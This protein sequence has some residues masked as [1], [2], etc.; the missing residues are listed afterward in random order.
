MERSVDVLPVLPI[1]VTASSEKSDPEENLLCDSSRRDRS[2]ASIACASN[3]NFSGWGQAFTDPR[4]AA[5]IVDRLTSRGH[6]I[7]TGT[8]AYRLKTTRQVR[9]G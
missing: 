1:M 9:K 8:D 4:L 2:W 6:S 3:A 5:A 7:N